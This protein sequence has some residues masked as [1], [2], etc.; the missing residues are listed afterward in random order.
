MTIQKGIR[1]FRG[2]Q[3]QVLFAIIER[4]DEPN[5]E[6]SGV[7]CFSVLEVYAADT[8]DCDP[9]W[10]LIL[11]N[12]PDVTHVICDGDDGYRWEEPECLTIREAAEASFIG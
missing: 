10:E 9:T 11:Q 2:T 8:A 3:G 1:L 5:G 7:F 4:D 12:H 6:G